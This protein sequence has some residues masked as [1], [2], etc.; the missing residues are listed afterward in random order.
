[1]SYETVTDE[2]LKS[3]IMWR[4]GTVGYY[5]ELNLLK[6][7]RAQ[8]E[9]HGYGRV[10]QLAKAIEDLWRNPENIDKYL[11]EQKAHNDLMEE[12]RKKIENQDE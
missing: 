8:C 6:Q 9:E 5:N 7:M 1:M 2:Q 4:E 12:Y 11:K 10:P 3:L